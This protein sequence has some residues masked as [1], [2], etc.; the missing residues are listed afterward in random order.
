MSNYY[1]KRDAKVKIAEEL[2]RMGWEVY[3]F[4]EDESDSMTD[5]YSPANWGGI[6]E[7]NGYILVVDCNAEKE[8]EITRYNP[9]Y[10]Q[11]TEADKNKIESLKNM[12]VE[13]GASEG[14][15]VASQKLISKIK[16]K[17]EDQKVS[18][19]EVIGKIPA[20]LG[21]PNRAMWHIEKDGC[22]VDKGNKLTIYADVPE[23]YM[24]DINSMTFA[25]NYKTYKSWEYSEE[26]G[27]NVQVKKERTL[28]ERQLKAVNE[29]KALILKLERIANFGNMCGDGTKATTEA[30]AMQQENEKMVKKTFTKTKKVIK[31]VKVER[32]LKVGDY[33]NYQGNRKT[34]CYWKV[35]DIDEKRKTFSYESTGK[36][37]QKLK[38]CKRY[39]NHMDKLNELYDIFELQE[40]EEIETVEKWVK[41]KIN[42]KSN[43][44]NNK[45][46]EVKETEKNQE[47]NIEV[48]VKFNTEK[49]GIELYFTDKPSEKIRTMLKSNSYRW[50][51]YNKCWYCKDTE[52]QREILINLGWLNNE[53]EKIIIDN[54]NIE[55]KKSEDKNIQIDER[56]AKRSKENMSFS[57][58]VEGSATREFETKI[59]G[60]KEQIEIEKKKVNDNGKIL[61]DNLFI[62]YKNQLAEWTNKHNSNGANHV[63]VM[64]SGAGNYNMKKHERYVQREGNLWK[65]YEAI[66]D[67][68]CKINKIVKKYESELSEVV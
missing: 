19:Y 20:H 41:V 24:F 42:N 66:N 50:A 33:V 12:T 34:V 3:G 26:Q 16:A 14:E 43:K 53:S 68:D 17:Y 63:S 49:N 54:S 36:K 4:K 11:M 7:K 8:R 60:V 40:V 28:S 1:E 9:N 27:F 6:A 2:M 15:A 62:R 45:V 55:I 51:K 21:N 58:Y 31:P 48:E 64:I 30:G 57:D 59:N 35:T 67:I 22:L 18:Q 65:E 56:L 10:I 61:L 13:R 25:D 52:D 38:N 29:F 5:Y 46:A 32:E 39:Y 44:N 37:Y 23:S 47:N